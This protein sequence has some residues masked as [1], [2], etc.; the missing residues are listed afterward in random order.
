HALVLALREGTVFVAME[1]NFPGMFRNLGGIGNAKLFEYCLSGT[2]T[3]IEDYT[4]E[5]VK[6]LEYICDTDFPDLSP[7]KK[8]DL[9]YELK[10][11]Y[12]RSALLLSGGVTFGIK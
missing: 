7:E 11:S 4:A 5:V 2:K 10:Q 6:Q 9:F 1:I 12:G 8:F 3:L